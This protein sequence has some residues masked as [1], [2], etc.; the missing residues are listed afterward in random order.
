VYSNI[1]S[2]RIDIRTAIPLAGAKGPSKL[3]E[4]AVDR[5]YSCTVFMGGRKA[6]FRKMYYFHIVTGPLGRKFHANSKNDLKPKGHKFF[7]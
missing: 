3:A 4:Q 1:S 7:D 5:N 6:I 2:I